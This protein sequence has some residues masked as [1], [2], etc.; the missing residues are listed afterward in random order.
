MSTEL[1]TTA[2]LQVRGPA[3]NPVRVSVVPIALR[4]VCACSARDDLVARRTMQSP[5]H[6]VAIRRWRHSFGV[7]CDTKLSQCQGSSCIGLISRVAAHPGREMECSHPKDAV[8]VLVMRF[9]SLS[10]P[11]SLAH[12]AC[13]SERCAAD[14]RRRKLKADTA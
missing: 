1:R 8:Y 12:T 14:D 10:G 4:A 13:S 2:L 3:S 9:G 6:R 5:R 7:D 11:A